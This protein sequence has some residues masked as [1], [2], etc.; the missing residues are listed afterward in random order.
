MLR[1][2]TTP[3]ASARQLLDIGLMC[4]SISF[5]GALDT[6]AKYLVNVSDLP[7]VQVIWMRF[8]MHLPFAL[9]LVG[10]LAFVAALRPS[11]PGFQ[12]LRSFFLLATTAFNFAALEYLQL[13]QALVIFF[14]GPLLI[15]GLAG[16]LLGEWVG[17][18]RLLA[19]CTGFIGVIFVVKPGF[20]GVHWAIMFSFGAVICFSFYNI[21]TRFL[22]KYDEARVTFIYSPLFG[23][24]AFAPLGLWFWQWPADVFTW[25]LLCSM[26]VWGGIGHWLL[27]LAH[28][29][30]QAPVLAPFIYVGLLSVTV[31]QY[32][33]FG[34]VPDSWTIAGGIIIIGAGLYLLYRERK[35]KVHPSLHPQI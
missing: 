17:W 31:L 30:T 29:E 1:P 15:A 8:V 28:R 14:L 9:T 2:V 32:V 5:F 10:P 7:V 24:L 35:V 25:V 12:W 3:Q 27:I 16:P 26:G 11:R 18:R 21:T 13:D 22:A 6:T 34:D 20:G 4:A 19:I 23:I 33:V